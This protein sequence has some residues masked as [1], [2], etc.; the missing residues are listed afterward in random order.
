[1]VGN[2]AK[3]HLYRMIQ[4][5]LGNILK[6]A[7][8]SDVTLQLLKNERNLLL[9]VEDNGCG[10]APENTDADGIGLSNIKSRVETLHG[11]FLLESA[12]GKGVFISIEIPE[13]ELEM[14]GA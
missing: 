8:A 5:L 1:M 6:H 12:P 3:I 10:F 11:T 4:E 2:T 9:T 7:K 13:Q 14:T